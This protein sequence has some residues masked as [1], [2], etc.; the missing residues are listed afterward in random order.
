M[1][2]A[3]VRV[4][5]CHMG[6]KQDSSTI[7]KILKTAVMERLGVMAAHGLGEMR[8]NSEMRGKCKMG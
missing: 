8:T 2:T 1:E 4:R 3:N 5:R 7:G 6:S